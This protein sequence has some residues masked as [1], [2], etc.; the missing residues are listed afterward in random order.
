MVTNMGKK[1]ILDFKIWSTSIT[2]FNAAKRITSW[3]HCIRWSLLS[4]SV[5]LVTLSILIYAEKIQSSHSEASQFA[6]IFLSILVMSLSLSVNLNHLEIRAFQYHEC[7]RKI[8]RLASKLAGAVDDTKID[9]LFENYDD[10]LD[11]YENH[12]S[13]DYYQFALH[14]HKQFT[15]NQ[16]DKI[17]DWYLMYLW[18]PIARYIPQMLVYSVTVVLPLILIS[19]IV[20]F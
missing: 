19:R 6:S 3:K 1:E 17:P 8:R 9:D 7:G 5:Y 2:R 10:I 18:M 15:E 12:M 20:S 4:S 11:K 16:K 14:N 13:I